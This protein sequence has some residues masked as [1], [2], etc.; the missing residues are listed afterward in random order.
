MRLPLAQAHFF[1]AIRDELQ[2]GA[3]SQEIVLFVGLGVAVLLILVLA[4]YALARRPAK[5]PQTIDLLVDAIDLLDLDEQ[6]RRDLLR[7]ARRGQLDHPVAMLLSPANLARAAGD[8]EVLRA[9]PEI[10]VR[11]NQLSLRLFEAPLPVLPDN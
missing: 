1:E 11:L 6:T 10:R 5:P 2:E 7:I 8:P 9:D 4:G 3:V